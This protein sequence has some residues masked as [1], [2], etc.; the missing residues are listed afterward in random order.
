MMKTLLKYIKVA[1]FILFAVQMTAC[2]KGLNYEN[3][4]TITPEVVWNDSVMIKGFLSDI[5]SIPSWPLADDDGDVAINHQGPIDNYYYGA[6]SVAT[7]GV[8]LQYATIEKIN[9]LL[10]QLGSNSSNLITE[11]TKNR[12]IGQ[13]LFW[14][15][16]SY[17]GMVRSVGGIPIIL[18][19]QD[20][21]DKDA[22]FK[23]RNKTS[24]C[25]DQIFKD[26]DTAISL[27]PVSWSGIDY[28]RIDK[29]AA[30]AFKGRVML[31]YA[32]PLFNSTNDKT[33]WEKAYSANLDA[34]N[35][36]KSR[37]NG[38]YSPF[39]KIWSVEG[40]NNKE[41]VMAKQ[42]YYPDNAFSQ[43]GIRPEP[44][45]KGN[46]NINQPILSLLN[47]FPKRDGSLLV[48]DPTKLSDA[49]YNSQ[50]LTDFVTNRD[51]RF[52]ATIFVPGTPYPSVDALTAN[53]SLWTTY[54]KNA[55]NVNIAMVPDQ[56]PGKTA[57]QM[58]NGFFQ[59]KGVDPTL[60]QITVA[61]AGTDWIEI[62]YAEVLMN[63]GE[64]ANQVGKSTEALQVLYD[65]RKRAGITAGSESHYGITAVSQSDIQEAYIKE[66]F[67]E[68]A[69]EGLRFS[70]L[71]R[72][73]RFDILNNQKT[74][75]GL[76]I[77]LKKG[78]T[79]SDWKASILDPIVRSNFQAEYIDNLD[80]KSNYKYALSLNHWFF[81]IAQG[82]LDKN[83]QLEQN[84]EWDGTFD[85][86]Q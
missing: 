17:W 35:F 55:A 59:R 6:L 16:W 38:L 34:V 30:M 77:V 83:S 74:R 57:G 52:Y 50:Y 79:F 23:P 46:S 24:E 51:D 48:F 18:E 49:A 80:G 78:F 58:S 61:Q 63:Y 42:F 67:V 20:P 44:I 85:P 68:F 75:H 29:A 47:A 66:R 69:Y 9:Y 40:K 12:I 31:W 76:Q 22:L 37:G 60:E 64:A 27:L 84:N 81:P 73:K 39:S 1:V 86:L 33:R 56:F 21:S 82:D 11:S 45:T 32:S 28:G 53:Q 2:L 5:Y 54:R 62:R 41:I 13:T 19:P 36:L 43:A 70:D 65:I 14:R 8:G 7:E 25:I 26:I 72:W 15:A 3:N 4:G 10:Y 71:R